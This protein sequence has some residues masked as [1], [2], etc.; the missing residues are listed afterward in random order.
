[1]GIP[2]W[3]SHATI[4]TTSLKN[5]FIISFILLKQTETSNAIL[6]VWAVGQDSIHESD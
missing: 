2:F 4:V 1:M 6:F 3:D 5:L